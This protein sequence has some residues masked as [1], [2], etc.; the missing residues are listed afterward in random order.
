MQDLIA[1]PMQIKRYYLDLTPTRD[2]YMGGGA[3][4]LPR[5]FMKL[6]QLY[7]NGGTWNGR[8]ILTPERIQRATSPPL[9]KFSEASKAPYGYPRWLLDYPY[10]GRTVHTYFA[11]GNGNQTAMGIPELDLVVAIY[12]GNYN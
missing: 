2:A 3:R 8:R 7:V 12:G 4:F 11:S 10:K 5:D 9:Y 1:E 6:A